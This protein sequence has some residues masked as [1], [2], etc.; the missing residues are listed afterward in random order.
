MQYIAI[1]WKEIVVMS[2][3]VKKNTFIFGLFIALVILENTLSS[4]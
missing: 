3:L 1:I 4:L 2:I